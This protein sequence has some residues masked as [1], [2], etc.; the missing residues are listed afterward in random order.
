MAINAVFDS[1]NTD[2]ARLYRRRERIPQH[3]GT[4][5]NVCTMVSATSATPAAPGSRSPA[6]RRP[7]HPVP[8]ATT[9]P[10]PRARTS[11]PAS[12]TRSL[13][14]LKA[15]DPASHKQLIE[16]MRQLETHH[17]DLCDIEFT[18][19]RG[20]LWMLQTRVGKR[21]AAAG[22]P[23]RLAA[24]R[25]NL[26]TDGRGTD[27]P[28]FWFQLA[29]LMF[30]HFDRQ[31]PRELPSPGD[32]RLAGPAVGRAVFFGGRQGVP[33]RPRRGRHAGPPGD[34]PRRPEGMIAAAGILTAWRK[35]SHAPSSPV[36]WARR[37]SWAPRRSTST[38]ERTARRPGA[39]QRGRR[40]QHR[41]VH[42]R[43]L[44]G[45]MP[46]V[47]SPVETLHRGRPGASGWRPTR[48]HRPQGVDRLTHADAPPPR[49]PRERGH[50]RGR[51]ARE[52]PLGRGRRPVPHRAHVPRRS[53]V[54]DRTG[55]PGR[56]LHIE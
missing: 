11:S 55:H 38:P 21:T 14:D 27:P 52:I 13:D 48:D 3:L 54:P 12:A 17:R 22:V 1:W 10:T 33:G 40:D 39:D 9:S 41:R 42:R 25:R 6:T 32:G 20:K 34:Q 19:E 36:A 5:V 24:G 30:P 15:L 8:T 23:D 31:G 29:L 2:R 35:T 26:I 53:P 28:G 50:H 45:A 44:P 37:A 47:P 46:V 16:V 4:A 56:Y 51:G 49:D 18:I 43:D 7:A